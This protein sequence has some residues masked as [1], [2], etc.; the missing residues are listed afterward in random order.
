MFIIIIQEG[1]R[2][3]TSN[4]AALHVVK[5]SVIN[6][7]IKLQNNLPTEIKQIENFKDVKNKLKNFYYKTAF[8]LYKS[9]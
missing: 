7:G 6:M 2:I 9:F 3:C 8:I 4:Y 5:K 1:N